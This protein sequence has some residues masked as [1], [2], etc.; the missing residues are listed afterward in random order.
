M[1]RETVFATSGGASWR[2]RQRRLRPFR[3][4]VQRATKMELAAATRLADLA[5]ETTSACD[6]SPAAATTAPTQTRT[7]AAICSTH[8]AP[9]LECVVAAPVTSDITLLL[10]PPVPV[11]QVV[12]VPQV[13]VIEKIL[14]IPEI[15]TVQGTQTS[16]SFCFPKNEFS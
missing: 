5:T 10:E 4:F 16:D 12:Q 11:V 6:L 1:V 13:Q 7:Y 8:P 14:E 9:V 2:R 3:R 15:Q